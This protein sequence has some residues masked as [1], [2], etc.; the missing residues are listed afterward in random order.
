V[1]S[2]KDIQSLI[3]DIDS[4]ISKADARLPWSKPGNVSRERRI[5]ERVRS[6]LVSQQQKLLAAAKEPSVAVTP[7]Q[8]EVVQQ[9]VQAVTQ[10][11]NVLRADLR[12]PLQVDIE[13]LRQ[14]REALIQEI[15]HLEQRR[16]QIDSFNQRNSTQQQTLSEFSQGL[17]NR[18]TETLTQQLAQI[19]ANF[20]HRVLNAELPARSRETTQTHSAI[21]PAFP[22]PE[23]VEGSMEAHITSEQL[24]QF[25]QQSDRMLTNLEANQRAIFE[26]LLR[27]LQAYQASLARGIE[28]MHS[29]GTQGEMLFTVLVNR[30]AQQLGREASTRF[31]SP[32]PLSDAT[33]SAQEAGIRP[34]QAET[35]LPS[36]AFTVTQRSPQPLE[37]LSR[38]PES[39][40][41]DEL[42]LNAIT[43]Q[44]TISQTDNVDTSPSDLSELS[45]DES[46]LETLNSQDWDVAEGLDSENFSLALDENDQLDT[47]IQLNIDDQES[48]SSEAVTDTLPS[49]DDSEA[50][51]LLAWLNERQQ[52]TPDS[53]TGQITELDKSE[54]AAELTTSVDR[55]RQEIDELYQSLFGTDSVSDTTN[56]K[57]S[58]VLVEGESD[59]SQTIQASEDVQPLDND[60]STNADAICADARRLANASQTQQ[61][62]AI[63]SI[64]PQVEED[65]F[66]GHADPATEFPPAQPP[67]EEATG[68]SAQSWEAL[69]FED[70]PP[71]PPNP[72][73]L[74]PETQLSS[75]ADDLLINGNRT[76]ESDDIETIGTLTDLLEQMGLTPLIPTPESKSTPDSTPQQSE[77]QPSDS[78][79]DV[80]E[81]TY[82]PAL[83][84]ED[85]LE[86]TTLESDPDVEIRLNPNTLQ[87]L[88]QDLYSF[89]QSLGQSTPRR[90]EQ[91]LPSSNLDESTET[92]EIDRSQ[93]QNPPFPIP[94]QESLAED[95][96]EFVLDYLRQLKAEQELADGSIPT[97]AEIVE[98]DFDPD[99]FPSE[100]LELDRESTVNAG[101]AASEAFALPGEFIAY[102][103]EHV[104]DE[105]QWDEPTDGTTEEAIAQW[106]ETASLPSPESNV[107]SD[108]LTPDA[109]VTE[110]EGEGNA[111]M[112]GA[113]RET[114]EDE[115]S[116]RTQDPILPQDSLENSSQPLPEAGGDFGQQN[117][118][119][120]ED[121]LPE[122]AIATEQE[123]VQPSTDGL[124]EEAPSGSEM[125]GAQASGE[126]NFEVNFPQSDVLNSEQPDNPKPINSD[127]DPQAQ[128]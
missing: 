23:S 119:T 43:E 67:L 41:A 122:N 114:V 92:P 112:P 103:E 29:L 123:N 2:L 100:V 83:P 53:D 118:E 35:L 86:T 91:P 72:T 85:L 96:E 76:S 128:P 33:T 5:L 46:F 11:I 9:I 57:E 109:L 69:F 102:E 104:V 121:T 47:F 80:T 19:L 8:Q 84:D 7:A 55:R 127:S 120:G 62:F 89:E 79:V 58:D 108:S 105:M 88:Q 16:Q 12:Q 74:D 113:W 17:I 63:A 68:A 45:P 49:S 56:L 13:A 75:N 110:P 70:Y 71:S 15:Q 61:R 10:E 124:S 95:W 94:P 81:D 78:V 25:Q 77:S 99:L 37:P 39:A 54:V 31:S 22:H 20:E 111:A 26:A 3:A 1:T 42:N 82:T 24:R 51:F 126:S 38:E 125:Q 65:L 106:D 66:E 101:T 107:D 116:E 50:D 87:Q 30:L 28:K 52:D 44:E 18:C 32:V 21:T 97:A 117:S 93:P 60:Q 90:E 98:S 4:I 59:N 64:Q 40:R 14:Q 27:D 6:Y 34:T 115:S 73:D 36:D 48:H